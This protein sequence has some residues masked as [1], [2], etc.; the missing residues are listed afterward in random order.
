TK[1]YLAEDILTK[2]DRASMANSLEVRAPFLDYH[3]AEFAASLPE[4]Y[5]LKGREG[6]FIVKRAVAPML[7]DFVT[8]RPKKGFGIPIASWL[9]NEMKPLLNDLLAPRLIANQ[10]LFEVGYVQKLLREHENGVANNSKQL[11]TLLIFQL[12]QQ[13]FLKL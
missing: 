7:P 9:N 10:G 1:F 2:V 5:R 13:N 3:V 8:K 6:K 11:W 12:W 4:S